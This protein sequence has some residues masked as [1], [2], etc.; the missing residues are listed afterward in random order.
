MNA[1]DRARIAR[2]RALHAERKAAAER[3]AWDR[4]ALRAEARE[5][6]ADESRR[7]WNAPADESAP[8]SAS[9]PAASAERRG[10]LVSAGGRSEPPA[11]AP[12]SLDEQFRAALVA[13]RRPR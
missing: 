8:S 10:P 11:P 13:T 12:L 2:R 6:M 5:R 7:S 9:T 4:D 1:R 3:R